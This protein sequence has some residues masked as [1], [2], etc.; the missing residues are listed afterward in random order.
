MGDK[1]IITIKL[2]F[3]VIKELVKSGAWK[4]DEEKKCFREVI[5]GAWQVGTEIGGED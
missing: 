3:N 2:P 1:E 4:W 5:R